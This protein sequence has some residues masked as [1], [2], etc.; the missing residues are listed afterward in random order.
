MTFNDFKTQVLSLSGLF[1]DKTTIRFNDRSHPVNGVWYEAQ[2]KDG[3]CGVVWNGKFK[4]FQVLINGSN[5][6]DPKLM[7]KDI[8]KALIL[9]ERRAN[10]FQMSEWQQVDT[11]DD[12]TFNYS[13]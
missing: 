13:V 5:V 6:H 10:C 8:R 1:A 2:D 7:H 4:K 9:A 12:S 3:F 11:Y